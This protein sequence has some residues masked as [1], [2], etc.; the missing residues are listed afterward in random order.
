MITRALIWINIAAFAWEIAVGGPGVLWPGIPDV[1]RINDF[2][3]SPLSITQAHQYYRIVTAAFLHANIM[4]IAVNM[5]S[6]YVLGR[7]IEMALRP[8]RMLVVYVVSLVCSGIAIVLFSA[9]LQA[10]LGASGAIFGIFGALFAIGFK[11]GGRAGNDLVRAN[12]GILVLNLIWSFSVPF[13]SWQAHVGGL[14]AGFLCAYIVYAPP[15]PVYAS[16]VDAQSGTHYQSQLEEPG[17][18]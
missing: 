13:I 7:F 10:T 12:V 14:I 5:Y 4:H 9:P 11:L 16:V 17:E 18:Q 2:L 15:R 1:S 8:V 3:L 6:L